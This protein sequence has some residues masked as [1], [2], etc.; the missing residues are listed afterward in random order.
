MVHEGLGFRVQGS[1]FRA[2]CSNS[3]FSVQRLGLRVHGS[4]FSAQSSGLKGFRVQEGSG[5]RV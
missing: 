4:G 1:G 5:F 2:Q 3:G